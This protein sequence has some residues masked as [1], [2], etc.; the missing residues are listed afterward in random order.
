M[1]RLIVSIAMACAVVV[2]MSGCAVVG[3]VAG[4][5]QLLVVSSQCDPKACWSL[6]ILE[7]ANAF[8]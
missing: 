3:G 2:F 8:F 7:V 5:C 4:S 1:K 6:D